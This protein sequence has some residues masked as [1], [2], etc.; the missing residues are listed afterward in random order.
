MSSASP[1]R[2]QELSPYLDD[3]LTMTDEQRV[4]WLAALR[5]QDAG[6]AAELE[7]LL[8]EREAIAEENFLED[9]V[10]DVPS[11]SPFAGQA[12][13]AYTL[14]AAIGHG[15]MSTVWLA[16]RND[17]RFQGRVAIKFLSIAVSGATGQ[18]RFVREGNILGRFTH[19]HIAHLMDAGVSPTGQPYLVLEYIEG[20]PIDEYCDRRNLDIEARI[21]LFL[22]VLSAVAHAHSHLIVHRDIKPSNVLVRNDGVV[23]LLDFGIAKLLEEDQSGTLTRAAGP[24]TPRFAAPEQFTNGD[25]TTA[26]DVYSLGVLLYV[27]LAGLHPSG[28]PQ[29]SA[30]ELVQSITALEPRKMSDVVPTEAEAV[31]AASRSATAEK[32]R[33]TLRGDLDTIV[34]KALKKDPQERYASAT[35]FAGD[36]R[37]Y[38]AHEPISARPDT[39]AYR[40]AKFVRRN[41]LHVSL[42]VVALLATVAGLAGTLMQAR[43]ARNERDFA[44]RQL[45]RANAMSG[46]QWYVLS[47]AAPSGK[48]FT[49]NDLLDRADHIVERQHGDL[50]TRVELLISIGGQYTVSDQ[51]QKST[52]LLQEAYTLSKSVPDPTV[53]ADAACKLAQVT[54]RSG[55]FTRA[56]ALFHEGLA[57][58]PDDPLYLLSR[59][60]CWVRGSEIAVNANRPKDAVTRAQTARE[61][62]ARSPLHSDEDDLDT[63]I[64]LASAYNFAGKRGEAI[65]TYQAAER[66][67]QTLGRDDTQ[68]AAGLYNNWGVTL[69]R[70]GQPLQAEAVLRRSID[71]S[72]DGPDEDEIGSTTLGN[73]AYALFELGR[74]EEAQSYAERAY[75][76]AVASGDDMAVRFALMHRVRIYRAMG[77]MQSARK[78]LAEFTSRIAHKDAP[79]SLVFAL[80]AVEQANIAQAAGD[81]RSADRRIDEALQLM[82]KLAQTGH[83]PQEYVS[84]GLT[85]RAG[86]ELQLGRAADAVNDATRATRLAEQAAVPGDP[87]VDVGHAY[88][89]LG[90]ALKAQGSSRARAAFRSAAEN[91]ASTLGSNHPETIEARRLSGLQQ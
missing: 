77:D 16:E 65:A 23:K 8:Q 71:I 45:A 52:R 74:L 4:V 41:R 60:F 70:A 27:L 20:E 17:G 61:V 5:R 35:A 11:A 26:T 51:Y 84:K 56:E 15:G 76:K 88:L 73:Y 24:L 49:V 22:D 13:G 2:W 36:L 14:K 48:P 29:Q 32:L 67:L 68:M 47:D 85:V 12:F 30:A 64:V 81:L 53:R 21:R 83:T 1:K 43:R 40:A 59:E 62:L 34:A 42:A 19:P 31:I 54:S 86:I 55:D 87:S 38:L 3:A 10:L 18:A 58:L 28:P 46:L 80:I 25:V 7:A 44:F 75:Q 91:L 69:L 9:R 82:A 63:M 50:A 57:A 33:R 37:A 79:G 90:R 89:V 39:L 66:R 78:T 72:K 6:L